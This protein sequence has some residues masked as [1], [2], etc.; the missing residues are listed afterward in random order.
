MSILIPLTLG[1]YTFD[2]YHLETPEQMGDLGGVQV[3]QQ[4][5]FP[6]GI[7]TQST[8]GYFPAVIRWRA[9]FSGGAASDH[10]EQVKRILSAGSEII[11]S[12]GERAWSGLLVKFSPTARHTWLFDYELEFWPRID[13]S[14]GVGE[15]DD[16]PSPEEIMD[17][18]ILALTSWIDGNLLNLFQFVALELLDPINAILGLIDAAL[19]ISQ[20][21]IALIDNLQSLAIQAAIGALTLACAPLLLSIDPLISSPAWDIASR[22]LVINNLLTTAQAPRWTVQVVNPNLMALSA[23][24]YGDCTLWETIA[25]AN[26]LAD[27]Q[28]I[29]AFELLIPPP[30]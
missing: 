28:P 1:S 14:A 19:A 5:D 9:R 29:G 26:N 23:Q 10:A 12:W 24:Y 22:A 6:G 3:I 11:L 16:T 17:L 18:Q 7:R 8:Y 4:H 21:I 13:L 27:P 2:D 15:F 25:L 20:G 30:S